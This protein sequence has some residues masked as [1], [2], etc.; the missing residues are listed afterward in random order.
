[1]LEKQLNLHSELM[2]PCSTKTKL[3]KIKKGVNRAQELG[4]HWNTFKDYLG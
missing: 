1:M 2:S 4:A 3:A